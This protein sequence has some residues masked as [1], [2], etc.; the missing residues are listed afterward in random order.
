LNV[1]DIAVFQSQLQNETPPTNRYAAL[2]WARWCWWRTYESFA[3]EFGTKIGA[4]GCDLD[5]LPADSRSSQR[6]ILRGKSKRTVLVSPLAFLN[7]PSVA[8]PRLA[9]PEMRKFA[10]SL[11]AHRVLL[12]D[13]FRFGMVQ[14]R[15]LLAL[16]GCKLVRY[17]GGR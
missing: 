16:L 13:D 17:T 6:S 3:S 11:S 9:G 2:F 4:F 8:R 1:F 5:G 12:P 10:A 15:C 14:I 7:P